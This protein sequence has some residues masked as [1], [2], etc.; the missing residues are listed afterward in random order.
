MSPEEDTAAQPEE[1]GDGPQQDESQLPKSG[2]ETTRLLD[3]N[4]ALSGQSQKEAESAA[5]MPSADLGDLLSGL[6]GGG[7]EGA[8]LG[9]DGIAERSGVSRSA[10]S[11][12]LPLVLGALLKP[13]QQ[14]ASGSKPVGLAGI[15]SLATGGKPLNAA[16][17]EATGLPAEL[18]K[19]AGIDSKTAM[20]I[21]QAVLKAL[22]IGKT[23]AKAKPKKKPKTTAKPKAKPKP[24]TAAKPKAKPKP[25]TAAKP[26][27]KPK[28]KTSSSTT[29]A[30]PKAKPKPATAAKPK[31]KTTAKVKAQPKPKT[32]TK[33]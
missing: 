31:P 13:G 30:K 14:T 10:L 8:G 17:L 22:G 1:P 20:T 18:A 19:K 24:K 29:S 33:K 3:L 7:G 12:A 21:I 25:K 32:T 2:A 11:A 28:P 16:S 27:A 5:A 15:A 4:A 6:F 26:R 23:T 9:L